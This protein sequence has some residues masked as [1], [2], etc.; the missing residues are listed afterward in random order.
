LG[1]FRNRPFCGAL[2]ATASMTFGIYGMIFLLPLVWQ[3]SGLL[4][5]EMAGLALLPCALVFFL[6]SQRSGHLAQRIGV[7]AMTAGG[8]AVIGCGLLVLAATR[9]GQPLALAAVGLA[10]TGIGMGLN[11]GPLMSVAVEAVTA[12]R[13]GTASALINVARMAGATLGVA[14]L[15]AAFTL[16]HGGESGLRAAMLAGGSVQLVGA[17]IAWATVR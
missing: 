6:V 7:R 16:C 15:G 5:P 2:V 11:T 12:A 1:L 13:S 4:G 3:A 14:F 9:A 8:T 10:L 17:T